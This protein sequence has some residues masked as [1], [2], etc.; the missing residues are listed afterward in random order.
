MQA[1][2]LN[3]HDAYRR[4]KAGLGTLPLVVAIL[5]LATGLPSYLYDAIWGWRTLV[6]KADPKPEAK[7]EA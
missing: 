7:A 1:Y 6:S 3:V 2:I 5:G 4:R